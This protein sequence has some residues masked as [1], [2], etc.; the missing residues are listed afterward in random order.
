[1]LYGGI[2][3]EGQKY[4][5]RVTATIITI[6]QKSSTLFHIGKLVLYFSDH[7]KRGE[8]GME[9]FLGVGGWGGEG[10]IG[11]RERLGEEIGEWCPIQNNKKNLDPF[12]TLDL[13]F[14]DCF[15]REKLHLLAEFGKNFIS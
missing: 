14:W 11:G 8:E 6:N 3:F 12:Y 4:K 5:R 10:E 15:R 9:S 2:P 1:M 13:D 7:K